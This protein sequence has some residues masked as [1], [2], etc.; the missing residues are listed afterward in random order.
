MSATERYVSLDQ[1]TARVEGTLTDFDGSL[2]VM[3]QGEAIAMH[4]PGHFITEVPLAQPGVH[5]IAVR[6]EDE[7][8]FRRQG[9]LSV[10]YA[11][12]LSPEAMNPRSTMVVVTDEILG[13]LLSDSPDETVSLSA[14]WHTVEMDGD[15]CR[16]RIQHE[17]VIPH[18]HVVEGVPTVQ[19]RFP[20]LE[21]HTECSDSAIAL[22]SIL[23][24]FRSTIVR[25]DLV[26]RAALQSSESEGPCMRGFDVTLT[27][28]RIETSADGITPR[29][30]S[31]VGR[32]LGCFAREFRRHLETPPPARRERR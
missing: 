15:S 29:R 28:S 30:R 21:V 18:V 19:V 13:V 8:G 17:T 24:R 12:F 23:P 25:G 6:V 3:V 1:T 31:Q 4:H 14:D 27:E 7:N 2:E 9:D 22:P 26:V 16:R 11:D 5:A 20:Q 10:I 32:R